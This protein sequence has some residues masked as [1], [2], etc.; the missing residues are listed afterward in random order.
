M[1]EVRG[2]A[3]VLAAEPLDRQV[4]PGSE[5]LEGVTVVVAQGDDRAEHGREGIP[6]NPAPA[7]PPPIHGPIVDGGLTDVKDD[8]T[9]GRCA[10][11]SLLQGMFPSG[12]GQTSL[13][14]SSRSF[15]D[16][17]SCHGRTSW[18]NSRSRSALVSYPARVSVTAASPASSQPLSTSPSWTYAVA[19]S[20]SSTERCFTAPA[21]RH[22]MAVCRAVS[23]W[24]T[25]PAAR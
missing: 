22:A 13:R 1:L 16:S 20:V 9:Q 7:A 21:S 23:A 19:R 14:R 18:R 17:R 15:T 11:L 24:S 6:S 12:R 25:W 10:F 5:V 4:E 3:G 8:R 2:A